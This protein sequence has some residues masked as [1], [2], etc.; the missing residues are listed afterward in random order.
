VRGQ[1]RIIAEV[2][3][4]PVARQILAH[5]GLPTSPPRP[6][7]AGLFDTGPPPVDE[8]E[9]SIDWSDEDFRSW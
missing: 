2:E 9:A 3:E 5:L 8:P 7:Q 6:R 4:G 1:R